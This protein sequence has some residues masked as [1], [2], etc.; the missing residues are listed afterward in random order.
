MSLSPVQNAGRSKGE[1]YMSD[2][3]ARLKERIREASGSYPDQWR[4]ESASRQ[5]PLRNLVDAW[6]EH[7]LHFARMRHALRRLGAELRRKHGYVTPDNT[8][9]GRAD[10][11][12]GLTCIAAE[13]LHGSVC[14]DFGG[15]DKFTAEEVAFYVADKWRIGR[16]NL[17][18]EEWR[19]V[20]HVREQLM[21]DALDVRDAVRRDVH[22]FALAFMDRHPDLIRRAERMLAHVGARA[23]QDGLLSSGGGDK[24]W[25]G[26]YFF[27]AVLLAQLPDKPAV[28]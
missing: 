11:I 27:A 21:L 9:E 17:P 15:G 16:D 13:V 8:D 7:I 20:R 14:T 26:V 12:R 22:R 19:E 2:A 6:A 5:P 1:E 23:F 25:R 24:V 10:L 18:I 4:S 28:H 3:L